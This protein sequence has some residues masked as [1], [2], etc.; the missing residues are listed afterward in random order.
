[1]NRHPLSSWKISKCAKNC[2]SCNMVFENGQSISSVLIHLDSGQE[3]LDFCSACPTPSSAVLSMWKTRYVAMEASAEPLKKESTE[4]LLQKM[5]DGG[6]EEDQR[7][8]VFILAV[9][10]ERKKMLVE[11][12]IYRDDAGYLWRIYEQRKSAE[13]YLILDPELLLDELKEVQEKVIEL[14]DRSATSSAN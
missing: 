13:T 6:I 10:L 14:L 1:M 5:L 2:H 3:R 4:S 8:V 12:E 11:K 7:G 9:M